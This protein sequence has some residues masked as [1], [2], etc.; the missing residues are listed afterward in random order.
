M[1]VIKNANV[2][3]TD[4]IRNATVICDNG[5]IVD[6]VERY[7]ENATD[8]V[9]D[10]DG[11]YLSP[12]FIDIHVHGGGNKSAMSTNYRDIIDMAKREL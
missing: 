1:L 7:S 10:A 9:L 12:G 3:F 6:I 8:T 5:K 4:K 2:I 11:N